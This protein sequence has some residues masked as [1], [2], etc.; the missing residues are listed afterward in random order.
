MVIVLLIEN[1]I[2]MPRLIVSL[3]LSLLMASACDKVKDSQEPDVWPNFELKPILVNVFTNGS[4][5]INF[6]HENPIPVQANFRIT[7]QPTN[8]RINLDAQRLLFIYTP[9]AGWSGKDSAEFEACKANQCKT[10][11]IHFE[12]TDT[13]QPCT[14][15][16]PT[17]LLQVLTGYRF[18]Q[19]DSLFAC[20]GKIE[21]LLGNVPAE[22][23]LSNGRIKINFPP[24]FLD[25]ASFG[26]EVCSPAG[27]CATSVITLL[28]NPD[29]ADCQNQFR[30]Q[31][32]VIR[33]APNIQAKSVLYDS[34]YAN[35]L[36]C[37]GDIRYQSIEV[38]G[39]PTRGTYELRSNIQ[40]RFIRYFK[41]PNFVS[42]L[43]SITYTVSTFSG[44]TKSTKV[45][46]QVQ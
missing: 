28:V 7:R 14:P 11:I 23:Q 5:E 42:G 36:S 43:D 30:P 32:D 41:D 21:R 9:R 25:S 15:F 12:V 17:Y 18:L 16:A 1:Q 26:Y 6:L 13:T 40:G 44:S 38:I 45:F 27:I 20:D 33:L 37:T 24:T 19:I 39:P 29:P 34:L 10:G 8:G 3:F 31:P 35:D 46:F 2:I 4:A 22:V